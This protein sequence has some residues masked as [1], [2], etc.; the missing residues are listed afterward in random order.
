MKILLQVPLLLVLIHLFVPTV[1]AFSGTQQVFYNSEI[2][3]RTRDEIQD[4]NSNVIQSFKA[5]KPTVMFY[6]FSEELRE[7]GFDPVEKLYERS[8]KLIGKHH[9]FQSHE[10]HALYSGKAEK[11]TTITSRTE[12]DFLIQIT[13]TPDQPKFISIM[14]T[15]YNTGN[16]VLF[17]IW[18][19]IENSWHLNTFHVGTIQLRGK[20]SADWYH[21]AQQIYQKGHVLP[22]LLRILIAQKLSRPA[23][24][25]RYVIEN[26]I[27][28]LQTQCRKELEKHT[29]PI[30]INTK[31]TTTLLNVAPYLYHGEL[32]PL[33][34]YI[35]TIELKEEEKIEA[36]SSD[37]LSRL[38][39]L[40]PG[41]SSHGK[42]VAFKIYSKIPGEEN[43][44]NSPSLN[45]VIPVERIN[46]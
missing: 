36:E 21:D 11:T 39:T 3:Q 43:S 9:F 17:S 28:E 16:I 18:E 38:N 31:P 42:H 4:L 24:F 44:Q 26:D 30:T 12:P 14:E 34:R 32:I 6:M 13:L 25:I 20:T 1:Y 5:D 40:F 22:A 41:F 8:A 10:Y 33:A 45:M 37:L 15:K 27:R 19:D 46:D 23:P 29:F 2:D 35:T 7:K